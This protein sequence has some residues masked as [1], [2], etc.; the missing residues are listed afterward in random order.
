MDNKTWGLFQ[1]WAVN[2]E[3]LYSMKSE[4]GLP[5]ESLVKSFLW[6]LKSQ[7]LI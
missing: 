7:N 3:I 2:T 6:L 1:F 4:M 5:G